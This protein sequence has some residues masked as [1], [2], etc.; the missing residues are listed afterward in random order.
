MPS[1]SVESVRNKT[2][3]D[4]QVYTQRVVARHA[5]PNVHW[6]LHL[7]PPNAQISAD[8]VVTWTARFAD[9]PARFSV[10]AAD[11]V[12]GAGGRDWT[13]TVEPV[14]VRLAVAEQRLTVSVQGKVVYLLKTPYRNGT[15]HVVFEPL[16]FIAR[17]E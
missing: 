10:T 3:S 14:A 9:S 11:D 15:T 16:D 5:G 12:G 7:H 2:V 8:G 4:G 13:V 6:I 17:L 1:L